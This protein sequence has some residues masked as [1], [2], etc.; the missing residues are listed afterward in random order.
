M[1]VSLTVSETLHGAQQADT[2]AGG[3]SG[4]DMGAVN[5]N[6]YAPLTN[7]TNNQGKLDIYVSH[8]ATI[9]PITGVATFIQQYG[10]GTGY[11]Y[12]GAQS[13]A[14]DYSALQSLGNA[15]GNS[16]NNAD[17]NSGGLWIDMTWN[18]GDSTRFDRTNFPTTVKVYGNAN[19]DGLN[20]AS[21]IGLKA[22]ACVYSNSGTETG[23]SAPVDGKIGKSG[24]TVLG[25]SAHVQM[26]I[27]L[28]NN[29]TNGGYIQWEWVIAY[30]FTA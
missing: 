21:A 8:N 12:G 3:G 1:T 29:Y 23:G 14:A 28:P 25:D 5:N 6:S 24:D 10:T 7:K 9:D 18:A 4:V 11:T 27:Y 19:T 15:S 26:R 13:A 17:G 2:L 20:L 22:S 16:K 30:S